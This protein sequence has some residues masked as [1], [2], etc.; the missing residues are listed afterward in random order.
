MKLRALES[1][2][3]MPFLIFAYW[4]HNNE[5]PQNTV[6]PKLRKFSTNREHENN[7]YNAGERTKEQF[8]LYGFIFF[9]YFFKD[10]FHLKKRFLRAP[11]HTQH[12]I[13]QW[14]ILFWTWPYM[15]LFGIK[16]RPMQLHHLRTAVLFRLW[17]M[18]GVPNGSMVPTSSLILNFLLDLFR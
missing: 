6:L 4:N 5:T 7:L 18:T 13:M 15:G 11:T 17:L 12:C 16:A 8:F 9:S 3:L 14:F 1:Q 10:S 2:K